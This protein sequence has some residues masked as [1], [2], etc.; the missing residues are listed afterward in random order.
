MKGAARRED[1]D[2]T[3][4]AKRLGGHIGGLWQDSRFEYIATPHTIAAKGDG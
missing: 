1:S 2:K 4:V 3:F